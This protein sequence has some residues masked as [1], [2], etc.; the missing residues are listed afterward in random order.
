MP[1]A[2]YSSNPAETLRIEQLDALTLVYHRASGITHLL[3][4]PAPEILAILA[5]GP[6]T[7]AMVL[8]RLC[9]QFAVGDRDE[10]ALSA[11]LQELVATGLVTAT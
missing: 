7:Q 9:A 5:E 11:R 2:L 1:E 3:V 8:D 6:R 10:R 4:S